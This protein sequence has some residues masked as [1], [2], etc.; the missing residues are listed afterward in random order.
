MKKL[1]L[2]GLQGL[3]NL[4]MAC[5]GARGR[6]L[7]AKACIA[8][9]GVLP[10][11]IETIPTKRGSITFY[12]LDDLPLWRA[13]TLLTKEPETIEWIDSF[14]EGDIY[15]D[16]GA[17]VGIYAL[18]AGIS[19]KV[20]VLAFEPSAANYLLLNRNIDLNRLSGTVQAYCLAFSDATALNAL[21]MQTTAF[22]GALSSFGVPVDNNGEIFQPVYRQGMVGFSIDEFIARF[23][24]DFPNHLKVDVDGI[25]DLIVKGAAATLADPRLKSISIELD[26]ARPDYTNPVIAALEAVGLK[27]VSKRHAPMIE[28]GPFKNV[29]NYLFQREEA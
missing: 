3:A 5:A 21:N 17:N 23:S 2:G 7:F 15:W 11:V 10:E 28:N 18:Y 13:R 12:C 22:G 20:K 8:N 29:Y 9:G 24:P 4:L 1:I 27:L 25:E 26:D 16:V 6:R 19:G 14:K